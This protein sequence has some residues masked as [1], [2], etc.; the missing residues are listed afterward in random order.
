[1]MIQHF[2]SAETKPLFSFLNVDSEHHQDT[3]T[4]RDLITGRE[5]KPSTP[6]KT[7]R[8]GSQQADR[9]S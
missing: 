4:N 2:L 1:M 9:S 6:G 5:D 7:L 3:S 8:E